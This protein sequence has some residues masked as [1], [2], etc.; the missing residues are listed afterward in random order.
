MDSE[1]KK[2]SSLQDSINPKILLRKKKINKN[3]KR[4][5]DEEEQYYFTQN[6]KNLVLK[7]YKIIY[8]HV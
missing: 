3:K 8:K 6:N 1:N 2:D 5:N 4:E 7:E